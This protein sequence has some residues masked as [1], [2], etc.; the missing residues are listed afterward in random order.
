MN[1]KT[2]VGNYTARVTVVATGLPS[3]MPAVYKCGVS[4]VS[5]TETMTNLLSSIRWIIIGSGIN[6]VSF[7]E[8]TI[9]L[10]LFGRAVTKNGT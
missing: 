4:M 3:F 8:T 9:S 7:T 1:M 5:F 6:T 10:L 2:V